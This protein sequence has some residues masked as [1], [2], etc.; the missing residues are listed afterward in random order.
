MP[1]RSNRGI[2]G[3]HSRPVIGATASNA[4]QAAAI[5]QHTWAERLQPE[6]STV[7]GLVAAIFERWVKD[8]REGDLGAVQDFR[9]AVGNPE[10]VPAIRLA[11]LVTE[12]SPGQIVHGLIERAGLG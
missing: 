2:R 1:S 7:A 10:R 6:A 12:Y 4:S 5:G 11:V 9:R 8:A 3:R